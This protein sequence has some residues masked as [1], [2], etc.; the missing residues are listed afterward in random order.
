MNTEDLSTLR[1]LTDAL[2]ER[3]GHP[4]RRDGWLHWADSG[5]AHRWL[6]PSW[7]RLA[8]TSAAAGVGFFG[9]PRAGGLDD[10]PPGLESRVADAAAEQGWLLAYLN[11]RFPDGSDGPHF[12][13]LVVIT[14]RAAVR[15]LEDDAAHTEAVG[16]AP[17]A[18]ESIRIH[19]LTLTGPLTMRPAIR[20]DET[21]TIDYG[22]SPPTRTVELGGA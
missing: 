17:G 22:S 8:S 5:A 4:V 13:N 14:D 16:R 2:A 6:V 19:R 9:E 1:L 10:F 20:V 3:A 11:V 18:Y 21:L 15:A 7:E 12:A